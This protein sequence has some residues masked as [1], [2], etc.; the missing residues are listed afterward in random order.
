M[1]RLIVGTVTLVVACSC[2]GIAQDWN[3]GVLGGFGWNRDAAIRNSVISS[4]PASGEVG[5][6]SRAT[7]GVVVG[8]DLYR[9]WG[10]EIR[11]LFQ[12]GGP[13]IEAN[14]A[15]TSISGYSNLVTYDFI[16][17]PVRTES[18]LRPYLAGGAGVKAYTGTD[19][20][21]AGQQAGSR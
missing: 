11:W 19:D 10:G 8:E 15:K 3:I 14:G 4:P 2:S 9:H 6:P 5:F 18:G 16:V 12:W 13:Q 21:L 7:V 17:Y 1:M 20:R